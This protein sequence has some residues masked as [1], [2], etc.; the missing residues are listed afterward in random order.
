M[1]AAYLA[2]KGY[3]A[4]A[5]AYFNYDDLP[6]SLVNYPLEN[7]E[8]GIN[9]L[10]ARPEVRGDEIAVI[11]E[12]KGAELALLAGSTFR[13]IKAVIAISGNGVV[14]PGVPVAGSNVEQPAWTFQGRPVPFMNR[15]DLTPDQLKRI[16]ELDWTPPAST[17][18]AVRIL[19]ENQAAVE[20][21]S[22]P[23][24]NIN[25]P[26]LLISGKLDP[27]IPSTTLS[28]MVMARLKQAKHPF[29]DRHL[30]YDNGHVYLLPNF[31]TTVD[32]VI[33]PVT[34]MDVALGGDAE[35]RAVAGADAW[36]QLVVF[37]HAAFRHR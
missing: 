18:P 35:Q 10:K 32:H 17:L 30:N 25:G 2:S 23:V 15:K 37:L 31:P 28:D 11:G 16:Q 6:K 19:L 4:L 5:L 26:V 7:F 13:Q 3:A 9:W 24:E 34:K 12:S 1:Y 8:A 22:M 20:K 14:F 21:A 33:H 36:A 27:I 29:P